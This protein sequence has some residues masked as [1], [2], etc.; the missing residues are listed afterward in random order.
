MNLL[1][2]LRDL[3]NFHKENSNFTLVEYGIGNLRVPCTVPPE[4]NQ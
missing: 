1:N 2:F 3:M 4:A